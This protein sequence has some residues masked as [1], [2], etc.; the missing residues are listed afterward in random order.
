[1]EPNQFADAVKVLL[2]S[3]LVP[4]NRLVG[5]PDA[6]VAER[7]GLMR[8]AVLGRIEVLEN[9]RRDGAEISA[10]QGYIIEQIVR[11]G[12]G[13][14]VGPLLGEPGS[15]Q[16]SHERRLIAEIEVL[17]EAIRAA[18]RGADEAEAGLKAAENSRRA[19]EARALEAEVVAEHAVEAASAAAEQLAEERRTG[20][21]LAAENA[22]LAARVR[23]SEAAWRRAEAATESGPP[24]ERGTPTP[25]PAKRE[26]PEGATEPKRRTRRP[27]S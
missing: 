1:M 25:R 16:R 24:A 15:G 18:E 23:E 13:V 12:G 3:S 14:P 26:T 27:R 7:A 8:E 9:R 22:E 5:D 6:V 20:A 19:A 10:I 4:L 21:A 17:R 2:E 11:V